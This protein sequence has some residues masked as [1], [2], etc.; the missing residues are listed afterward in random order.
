M[1]TE[2]AHFTPLDD[3]TF[4]PTR[5]AN[6]HWGDDHVSGPAMVGL[7]AT[8]LENH[9][10]TEEFMPSRLTVDLFRAAR[11]VPT[12][13]AVRVVRDGRRVHTSDCEVI[14]DGRAVARGTLVQYRRSEAPPGTQ[15]TPESSFPA[16]P[17]PDGQ[18]MPFMYSEAEGWTRS[19]AAHQN[20]SRKTFY[21][22]GIDVIAGQRSSAFV[23]AAVL[24]ESTSLV[25]NLGTNGIGYINGD[26]TVA[27]ARLPRDE[28]IGLR[29]D[30]HL[31]ADGVAVG[32]A[33]L[34]DRTGPFGSGVVTVV[35]NPAAQ[36]DFTNASFQL[37][38][39]NYE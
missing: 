1:A 12:S 29:A 14:Q 36:I 34:F 19:P 33:T 21:N 25:T 28:W 30:S 8:V 22:K 13:V 7:M 11:S 39:L 24:A 15:W 6:S 17:S 2:I 4:M 9:Y 26:L 32:T 31:A 18:L 23:R 20:A 37:D 35:A 3:G 10:G 16:L 5:F 27:L 38:G